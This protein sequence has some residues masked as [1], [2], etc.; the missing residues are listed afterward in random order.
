MNIWEVYDPA[1]HMCQWRQKDRNR[2]KDGAKEQCGA[3]KKQC[4]K[5]NQLE[6]P[7]CQYDIDLD[8]HLSHRKETLMFV[9]CIIIFKYLL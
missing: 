1:I 2:S 6:K 3:G 5:G 8:V 4:N 9:L 7:A